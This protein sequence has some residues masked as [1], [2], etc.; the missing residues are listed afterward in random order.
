MK[1]TETMALSY[2]NLHFDI[3]R[4]CPATFGEKNQKKIDEIS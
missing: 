1:I 3:F 2:Q 4:P